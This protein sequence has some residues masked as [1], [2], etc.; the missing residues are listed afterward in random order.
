[1]KKA[2]ATAAHQSWIN[3]NCNRNWV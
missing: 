2:V 3:C 1:M